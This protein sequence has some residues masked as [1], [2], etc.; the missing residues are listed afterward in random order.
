MLLAVSRTGLQ[1]GH[2]SGQIA[3]TAAVTCASVRRIR[4]YT[5]DIQHHAHSKGLVNY[6]CLQVASEIILGDQQGIPVG[7]N[8]SES[9]DL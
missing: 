6:P 8:Q 3:N 7:M 5:L 9:A 2:V 4:I 1:F